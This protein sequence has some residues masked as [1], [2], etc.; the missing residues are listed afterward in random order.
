MCYFEI[1]DYSRA[2]HDFERCKQGNNASGGSLYYIKGI[3][4]Y[5]LKKPI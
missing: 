3:T 4:Y 5:K 2:I 1:K